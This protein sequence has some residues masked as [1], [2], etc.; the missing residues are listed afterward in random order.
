MRTTLVG[1]LQTKCT[2]V[3][4]KNF[5][6]QNR[7]SA[8]N[9][10]TEKKRRR[11]KQKKYRT[12]NNKKYIKNIKRKNPRNRILLRLVYVLVRLSPSFSCLFIKK[13]L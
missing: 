9:Y 12:K 1:M 8:I 10:H 2:Y 11:S 4:V 13:Y 3:E 7:N 6:R 5:K